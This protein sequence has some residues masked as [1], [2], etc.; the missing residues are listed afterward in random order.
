MANVLVVLALFCFSPFAYAT[1]DPDALRSRVT[2]Y[3]DSR[4]RAEEIEYR[5][6]A[7][8]RDSEFQ[9]SGGRRP[10]DAR[11]RQALAQATGQDMSDAY[12]QYKRGK[13]GR[14]SEGENRVLITN[15]GFYCFMAV[16]TLASVRVSCFT[17]DGAPSLTFELTM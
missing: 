16:A 4:R 14:Y 5:R 11:T 6:L 10:V 7:Q 15:R 1:H 17:D 8:Q 2:R 13:G 3:A 9:R 12:W